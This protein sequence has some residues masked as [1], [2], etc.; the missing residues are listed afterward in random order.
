MN[1]LTPETL[2]AV[3]VGGYPADTGALIILADH[4]MAHASAWAAATAAQAA[5]IA[6]LEADN[7]KL[8]AVVNR[9]HL[10][11]LEPVLP[12]GSP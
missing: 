11:I 8:R 10:G 12:P 4:L 9:H 2:E 3:P 1:K 7:R 5:R 6:A